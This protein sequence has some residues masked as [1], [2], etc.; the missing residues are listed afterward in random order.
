MSKKTSKLSD[1]KKVF[2]I[3]ISI[4]ISILTLVFFA[5]KILVNKVSTGTMPPY[6][7]VILLIV[8]VLILFFLFRK[9]IKLFKPKAGMKTPLSKNR[10]HWSKDWWWDGIFKVLVFLFMVFTIL[11][12]V[13]IISSWR[14][15]WKGLPNMARESLRPTPVNQSPKSILYENRGNILK[16]DIPYTWDRKCE[17]FY[18]FIP[19]EEGIR[20][21]MS[22]T[23][24]RD[25]SYFWVGY[26]EKRNGQFI[27]TPITG[28][29]PMLEGNYTVIF[30]KDVEIF[31][32]SIK[33]R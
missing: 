3:N 8:L 18:N 23:L 28:K 25:P 32:E 16:A 9:K 20:T 29:D 17:T 10:T 30:D 11:F 27:F 2:L 6:T 24:D 5:L 12:I 14:W 7:S 13:N 15:E 33:K 19:V 21:K 31:L 4:L 1:A 22:M 26:L